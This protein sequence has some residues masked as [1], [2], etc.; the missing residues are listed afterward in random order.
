MK[1]IE[2]ELKNT[3]YSYV[4]SDIDTYSPITINFP[5]LGNKSIDKIFYN[6][7]NYTSILEARLLGLSKSKKSKFIKQSISKGVDCRL[8]CI[9]MFEGAVDAERNYEGGHF[10]HLHGLMKMNNQVIDEIF[11][12]SMTFTLKKYLQP[13]ISTDV[14]V[15]RGNPDKDYPT[16]EK[17][18]DYMCKINYKSF[19]YKDLKSGF[20]FVRGFDN[21]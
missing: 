11:C 12:Q 13:F 7:K 5:E 21:D 15:R 8:K 14:H 18:V 4:E 19:N 10:L 17:Y 20:I 1:N 2:T 16:V 9:F 6:L 3:V